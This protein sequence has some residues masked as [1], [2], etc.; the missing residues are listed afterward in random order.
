MG[1]MEVGYRLDPT[2]YAKGI[3]VGKAKMDEINLVEETFMGNGT[4]R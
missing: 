1:C 2:V 4:T 3:K